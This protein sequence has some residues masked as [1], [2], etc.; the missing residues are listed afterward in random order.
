[1][2]FKSNFT[3][4]DV[5]LIPEQQEYYRNL[6]DDPS[7]TSP[8]LNT[9]TISDIEREMMDIE[10]GQHSTD[11]DIESAIREVNDEKFDEEQKKIHEKSHKY[12]IRSIKKTLP[13]PEKAKHSQESVVSFARKQMAKYQRSTQSYTPDEDKQN[14]RRELAQERRRES[15]KTVSASSNGGVPPNSSGS[16]FLHRTG[17]RNQLMMTT[18]P[19][20]LERDLRMQDTFQLL[21]EVHP[22]L[23]LEM[24]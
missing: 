13:D 17:I 11:I 12:N 24:V 16:D 2:S 21:M 15:Y 20:T 4:E 1:M 10:A 7:E 5:K 8:N 23:L 3:E 18:T 19:I 14:E 22:S 9:Q 6:P